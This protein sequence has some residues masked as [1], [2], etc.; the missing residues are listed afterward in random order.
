MYESQENSV[1]KKKRFYSCTTTIL[2]YIKQLSSKMTF[3]IASH[4]EFETR[5]MRRQRSN[6]VY[7]SDGGDILSVAVDVKQEARGLRNTKLT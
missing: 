2:K 6:I 5:K 3:Y 4:V 1:K 7:L